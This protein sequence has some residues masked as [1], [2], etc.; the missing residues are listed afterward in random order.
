MSSFLVFSALSLDFEVISCCSTDFTSINIAL[1]KLSVNIID[2]T[3]LRMY[4]E[5]DL[6]CLCLFMNN[7]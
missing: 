3:E 5:I 4:L 6:K 7:D 2:K 1:F